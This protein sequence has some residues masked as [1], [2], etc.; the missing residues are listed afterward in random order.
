MNNPEKHENYWSSGGGRDLVPAREISLDQ[1]QATPIS[2]IGA[3][4]QDRDESSFAISLRQYWHIMLKRR[5]VILS[6]ALAFVVL[7]GVRTFLKTPVFSAT[8]RIQIDRE[9]VKV[10]EGGSTSPSEEGGSDF[11]RT[12]FELLKS[13]AMAGRVASSVRI[14]EDADFLK[15]REVSPLGI[16]KSKLGDQGQGPAPSPSAAQ[17]AAIGLLTSNVS[18]TPVPGSRLVDLTY[19]DTNPARAERIAN[20]YVDAYV[21]STLDKRFQANAYAKTFLEDQLK[22]LKFR[23][24]ELERALLEFAEREKMVEITEKSSIAE[25]NLAAANVTVGQLIS[26][27]MKNEQLWRQVENATAINLPQLLTNPV[28]EVLRGQRKALETEYQEKLENFK[29]SYPAMVQISNKLREIDRQLAAEVK[30]IRTS[31]G[32]AYE[33]SLSQEKQMKARIET[34]RDEVLDLQKKGIQ[35]NILK[36]EVESNRSLYNSLLQR[37]KEVDIA[38]GVGAN[39]VF[40]VDRA[41][42]RRFRR[43]RI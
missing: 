25:N 8:A 28:I 2:Q 11:L 36:R 17:E 39:N 6:I 15:A 10:V 19:N 33:S 31:L 30:T 29:P 26:E 32:A 37:F 12:Q 21:A 40:I 23:L 24:E 27:R 13:R 5:W 3:G 35:F 18:V 22:Q 9:P 38:G 20:A 43:S 16:L 34:L 42:T 1:I 7:G 4:W 41:T 14:Y